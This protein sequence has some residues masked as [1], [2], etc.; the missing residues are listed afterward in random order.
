M[1]EQELYAKAV[2]LVREARGKLE[3]TC[4]VGAATLEELSIAYTPG[5]AEPT[6][7]VRDNHALQYAYTSRASMLAIVTDGTAVLGLGNVGPEAAMVVMEGKG[8]ML[9][10][11][12]GADPVPLC[13]NTRD[14]DE[15]VAVVKAIEPSFGFIFLEDIAAPRCFDIEERLSREL[16]IPVFHD[17][18][19]GTA[20]AISAGLTNVMR[21]TGESLSDKRI[22]INGAGAS[23]TATA[24][25]LMELGA[26]DLTLCDTRGALYRGRE[27]MH[28]HKIALAEKTNG[29][30]ARTLAEAL[31]GA[32]I[33][34][35]LSVARQVDQDMVR[36]MNRDPVIFALANP[37]P[38]ILPPAAKAAGA[39]FVS[40][41]RFDY[42]NTVNNLMAFPGIVRG[43][44]DSG[45]K[46]ITLD[47][48][49]AAVRAIA[50]HVS[51]AELRD[52][53]L[54]PNALDP[55]L[56]AAVAA[57]VAQAARTEGSA[58]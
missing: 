4:K 15:I 13:L 47:M 56:A 55:G 8:V 5:V 52:D 38:D 53:F 34:I 50:A 39:R 18:Q 20:I 37:D 3:V 2:D 26:R 40:T 19:H 49:R 9:K 14:P 57:A 29:R 10:H 36:S 12:A 21:L 42:P 43:T 30:N 11:F 1:N 27:G 7:R 46:R 22:V 45:A 16:S 33:F 6:R 17:D 32:D 44:M 25:L 28:A 54:L 23:G 41:G 58:A 35:G 48:K 31:R 51:D 24:K